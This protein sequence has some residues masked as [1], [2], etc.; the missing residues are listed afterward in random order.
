MAEFDKPPV[1][2]IAKRLWVHG[3]L[4]GFV[5]VGLF[6]GACLS[7]SGRATPLHQEEMK[8]FW[9]P[10]LMAGSAEIPGRQPLIAELEEVLSRMQE[11]TLAKNL[12]QFFSVYSATFP[13]LDEKRRRVTKT[14]QNFDYTGMNF[15]LA[16]VSLSGD[17]QASARVTWEVSLRD[18]RT[19]A[20]KEVA[21]GYRVRFIRESGRWHIASL[22][23]RD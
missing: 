1:L 18:H 11:A 14:W 23:P 22:H 9:Q 16:E 21:R 15:R 3:F 19:G 20:V 17:D 5:A 2:S 13:R 10:S 4:V 6:L 7:L 12:V 8:T